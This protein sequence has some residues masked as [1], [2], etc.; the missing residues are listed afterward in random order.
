MTPISPVRLFSAWLRRDRL[1]LILCLLAFALR[2]FQLG[3]QSLWYDEGFSAWLSAQ[4]LDQITLK[5]AADI[6]PPLYYYLLHFWMLAGGQSEFAL[7]F[8]S[9]VPGVL[10][11]PVVFLLARKLV[12][13][14]TGWI[15]ALL[16]AASPA[17][18]WYSQEARMYMLL[19]LF[20]AMSSYFLWRWTERPARGPWFA[21]TV[22]NVLAVYLH[23]Y[24][25]FIIAF[26][27]AYFLVWWTR[28]E[29]RW[30]V[31]LAGAGSAALALAAYVPWARFVIDRL[32][33]DESYFEGI[34]P[35]SEVLRKTFILF[36]AGQTM[37]EGDALLPAA[38]F[39][40]L[41]FVGWLV[42]GRMRHDPL[43]T[44]DE[45][46]FRQSL[47]AGAAARFFLML[48]LA[49]PFILLYAVSY[50]RPKFSPRYLLIASPPFV[51][52][53]AAAIA[54]MILLFR[55]SQLSAFRSRIIALSL[56][57][58][59]CV[60]VASVTLSATWAVYTD[61]RFSKDDFRGAVAAIRANR[62]PDDPTVLVSGH[63]FPI[64][65][66]YDPTGAWIPLPDSPTLST[67]RVLGYNVANDLNRALAGKPGAWLL[68]WQ[69]DIVDPGGF[70]PTILDGQSARLPQPQSFWGV[71]LLHYQIPP[72]TVFL[73]K[74]RIQHSVGANYGGQIQLLGYNL[75][76]ATATSDKGLDLTLY[77]QALADLSVDY[78][79][80]LR[81]HDAQGHLLGK[82]D[83][84]PAT[85]NYPTNR[86][87]NGDI[88]FGHF[89]VPLEPGT[90]PGQYRVEV[91]VYSNAGHEGLD[92]LDAAGNP[93]GKVA[94]LTGLQVDRALVPPSP[95]KLKPAHVLSFTFTNTLA[96]L[97]FD[98]ETSHGQAG[99]AVNL[100]VYWRAL[101]AT[102]EDLA[103]R[104][105][106]ARDGNGPQDFS[107]EPAVPLQ[108]GYPTSSWKQGEIVRAQYTYYIPIDAP[109]G[110]RAF[111]L[112]V[113]D[114]NNRRLSA[115]VALEELHIDLSTRVFR[116]PATGVI[117]T[118][119]FGP[120]IQLY[121][122]NI[123]PAPV[124]TGTTGL[125]RLSAGQPLRVT[126][127]W[128]PTQR[129][130][131][132]PYSVFIH[133][134]GAAGSIVA[135]RDGV[136]LNGARPTPTWIPGE[137]LADSYDIAVPPDI[138]RGRYMLE[139]GLFDPVSGTRLPVGAAG[140][141]TN[142][143]H[144]GIIVLVQ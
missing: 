113:L 9:L 63:M 77:W 137:Y 60:L 74:P 58:A 121:G 139:V 135:Q 5:T 104:F 22:C 1:L 45:N 87:K 62:G 20:T 84:R 116:P 13:E 6:H 52:L 71:Q 78:Q 51:I 27:F 50:G 93:T 111:R 89:V 86:W 34:L 129:S 11:V 24:A 100:T 26:Q 7:R 132:P 112:A 32:Q 66:Y 114:R 75:P 128:H 38:M 107:V 125:A 95:D 61:P 90:P 144:L 43:P 101:N 92:V 88:L 127:F 41:A 53:C 30:G 98:Q 97:G 115:P 82:A 37:L 142:S 33:T 79:V 21:M 102:R 110:D 69:N 134:L 133:L 85:Y 54:A 130:L 48:Y 141:A 39:V 4:S 73:D 67:T 108:A 131:G 44:L 49:V 12:D 29:T 124:V 123:T 14:T 23:F 19:V 3:A 96:M 94:A 126:L 64:Y 40:L 76:A 15:A 99:D 70:V 103:V 59:A 57:G 18:I 80:S 17:Y 46:P 109:A 83:A 140:S 35:L 105:E 106:L 2:V 138:A 120:A 10:L 42:L 56:A 118:V 117:D 36:S 55:R 143:A 136:P 16:T 68:L 65:R 81:V 28:Q 8:L 47:Q 119:Q 72:N 91:T 122:Y 31:L 25:F